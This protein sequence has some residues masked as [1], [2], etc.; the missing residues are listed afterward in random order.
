MPNRGVLCDTNQDVSDRYLCVHGHFYQPPRENPWLE[1][2]EVQESAYP[3]HDWN[4]RIA[5]ECYGPNGAARI[6][7]SQGRITKIVNNYARI[8]FDFG[9]T[10]LSW[11]ENHAPLVY[12]ATLKG[13]RDSQA[14]YAGHGSALAQVYNHAIMPLATRRHKFTQAYWGVRDFEKRFGRFPEGM[15]LPETAVDLESLEVLAELGILFTIL[16]PHQARR[17]RIETES[18]WHEVNPQKLDTTV[19][20]RV[21][22]P[23]GRS[24]VVFFYNSPL[25]HAVAFEHLLHSGEEF[26]RRLVS[27][28]SP[29]SPYPQ[30]VH[31]ATDGETYGHHHRYGEMALARAL[32]LIESRKLAKLTSYGAFLASQPP[33]FEAEIAENT[34]WSCAHGIERWRSDCGCKTGGKAD[35]NQKWRKP[36]RRALSTLEEELTRL[37]DEKASRY[38]SDPV[39]AQEDYVDVVLDR[40]SSTLDAFLERHARNPL[41][42]EERVLVLKLLEMQ[43]NAMLTSTSC[44]WFFSDISGI[45]TVQIL[46]YA[47]RS[48]QL[49]R[50]LFSQDLEPPFLERLQKARSNV[51]QEGNGRLIYQRKVRTALATFPHVGAHLALRLL[52]CPPTECG[53]FYNYR[54][55]CEDCRSWEAAERRAAVGTARITCK[56]TTES[57]RLAFGAVHFGDH[58]FLAGAGPYEGKEAHGKLASRLLRALQRGEVASLV[59]LMDRRF[60]KSTLT[61]RRLFRDEQEA[62]MKS[63]IEDSIRE[64]EAAFRQVYGR[65]IPLILLTRELGIRPPRSLELAAQFVLNSELRRTLDREPTDLER[66]R[67]LLRQAREQHIELDSEGL[68]FLLKG[69]ID[70]LAVQLQKEF[71]NPLILHRLDDTLDVF[72][73]FPFPVELWSMQNVFYELLQTHYASR[74]EEADEGDLTAHS[75]I[76]H[77]RSLGEKLSVRVPAPRPRLK[78]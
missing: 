55:L 51:Q 30:L 1:A 13:D 37:F 66:I 10:L 45:E 47:G 17:M 76:Q 16:A 57:Y 27:A 74:E 62:L 46:Q 61:L 40:S 48:L 78:E 43:R 70:T 14:R 34:S 69:A 75:W 26:A 54:L 35:W 25:S 3:Y 23:S 44:A 31:I 32:D 36:L 73:G 2:I 58:N 63:A 12:E 53:E 77:V 7:D 49:A 56:T 52:F 64:A 33:V 29:S 71:D 21:H 19:P 20:Y 59:R 22:L 24:I 9:P 8:S 50:D 5:A 15:W 67:F 39:R 38:L 11:L 41:S 28:F 68:G 18:T 72:R 65:V 4:E 6:L 42:D 60:P